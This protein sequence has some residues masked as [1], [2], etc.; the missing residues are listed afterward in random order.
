MTSSCLMTTFLFLGAGLFVAINIGM[1]KAVLYWDSNYSL[2]LFLLIFSNVF[3]PSVLASEGSG[4]GSLRRDSK[5]FLGTMDWLCSRSCSLMA[6]RTS[7]IWSFKV[8]SCYGCIEGPNASLWVSNASH[9]SSSSSAGSSSD[10]ISIGNW[11]IL[12]SFR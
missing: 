11:L 1:S 10:L 4:V 8:S 7:F 12:V 5:L 9:P 6:G 3:A 2:D